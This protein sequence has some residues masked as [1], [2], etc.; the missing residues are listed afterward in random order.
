VPFYDL[1]CPKCSKEYNISAS[2]SEKSEKQIPC[3]DCGSFELETVF[4]GAPA[5]I[6]SM[7]TPECPNRGICGGGG[8]GH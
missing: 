5:Y 7:K 3:P 2:I 1:R 4:K 6:K 8:C